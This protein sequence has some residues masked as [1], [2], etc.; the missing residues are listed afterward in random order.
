MSRRALWVGLAAAVA[1]GC[2]DGNQ[3]EDPRP[4]GAA[5]QDAASAPE[6]GATASAPRRSSG[7][8]V[9]PPNHRIPPSQGDNPGAEQSPYYGNG[10]LWTA[11][12]PEGVRERPERDGSIEQKFPWWRGVRGRLT[13]TGRRLDGRAP[14]LRARIP[15]GYGPTGFQATAIMFPA[16][17]CWSVTGKAGKASLSFVTLVLKPGG[18]TEPS[19][20]RHRPLRLPEPA[21]EDACPVSPVDRRAGKSINTFSGSGIGRGPVYP[22]LGSSGGHFTTTKRSSDGPWLAA[23]S[24]GTSS[25]ATAAAC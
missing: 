23:S 16:E 3:P 24:S 10:R 18:T 1:L 2:G 5:R 7:C 17:G 4:Q 12:Y 11:L 6:A 20:K 13:I 25:R 21:T 19:R 15:D 14:T 8:P 22:G 9:T